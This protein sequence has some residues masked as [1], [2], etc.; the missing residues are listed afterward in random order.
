[1]P[2]RS[3]SVPDVQVEVPGGPEAQGR[4]LDPRRG[5]RAPVE[6]RERTRAAASPTPGGG[7]ARRSA[8]STAG[9]PARPAGGASRRRRPLPPEPGSRTRSAA[10]ARS[11]SASPGRAAP[12]GR[13]VQRAD[14]LDLVAEEVEAHGRRR[15][16]RPHVHD[17][18][19][20][21]ELAG[22]LDRPHAH[23]AREREVL[24]ERRRA[25][26]SP[27]R[28]ET[29]GRR[30]RAPR[31]AG[32][33]GRGPRAEPRRPRAPG[34]SAAP[35]E[36]RPRRARGPARRARRGRAGPAP[37]S[38]GQA[39]KGSDGAGRNASRSSRSASIARASATTRGSRPRGGDRGEDPASRPAVEPPMRTD[40]FRPRRAA[41]R[42]LHG[43]EVVRGNPLRHGKSG[44]LAVGRAG[45]DP[46]CEAVPAPA[47]AGPDQMPTS[48]PPSGVSGGGAAGGAFRRPGT[49]RTGSGAARGA[50]PPEAVPG[51]RALLRS[52]P[53][54]RARR[55]SGGGGRRRGRSQMRGGAGARGARG[56]RGGAKP[57]E[58]AEGVRSPGSAGRA[59]GGS[60]KPP[61]QLPPAR[62]D[63][64]CRGRRGSRRDWDPSR[65]PRR[66]ARSRP[67][68]PAPN[69]LPHGR[70]RRCGPAGIPA[71]VL[72]VPPRPAVRR[73]A[74]RGRRPDGSAS[75]RPFGCPSA[76]GGTGP[77]P[78]RRPRSG[79][80]APPRS[81][82]AGAAGGTRRRGRPGRP[83]ARGPRRPRGPRARSASAS[84]ATG[85][86]R[87]GAWRPAPAAPRRP[88]DPRAGDARGLGA[89][90]PPAP[91]APPP[92]RRPSW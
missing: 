71:R 58:P 66:A 32:R 84:R 73:V 40:P 3:S 27:P 29:Q 1:M 15:A 51:P 74:V 12:L 18:A 24:E 9:R 14:R 75:V 50:R 30:R 76:P 34:P 33:P 86:G 48:K 60:A 11:A 36:A 5:G 49:R 45:T 91:A 6:A 17:P 21:R 16:P 69:A 56:A 39:G 80:A 87:S 57:R 54:S 90:R 63:R 22:R 67:G 8:G 43:P 55:R 78:T 72:P 92:A 77:S 47:P 61:A 89:A 59:R 53:R 85:S 52:R 26:C 64:A 37:A 2:R 13:G 35:P 19:A 4:D 28:V 23:V 42:L 10:S 62:A 70:V 68:G 44:G 38:R 83:P 65:C 25:A 7:L 88:G 20:G 46:R 82:P 81:V 31:A 79:R 41:E